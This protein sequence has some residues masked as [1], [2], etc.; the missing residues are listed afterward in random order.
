MHVDPATSFPITS[1]DVLATSKSVSPSIVVTIRSARRTRNQSKLVT[2]P[3]V[4]N[5]FASFAF[6]FLAS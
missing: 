4:S 1:I 5:S 6:H 2:V 3:V